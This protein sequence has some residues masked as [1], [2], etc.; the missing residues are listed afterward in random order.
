MTIID[1]IIEYILD[2]YSDVRS[3]CKMEFSSHSLSLVIND[4]NE[5]YIVYHEY[6][7]VLQI[8]ISL[9]SYEKIVPAKFIMLGDPELFKVIK[10]NV[11]EVRAL[12]IRQIREYIRRSSL[13]PGRREIRLSKSKIC[14]K[15]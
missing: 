7:G 5:I 14:P 3:F 6:D 4:N 9:D 11:D 12:P 1:A 2:T 10:S 15:L 8:N 13:N